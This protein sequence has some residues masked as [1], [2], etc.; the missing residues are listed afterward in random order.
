LRA[1]SEAVTPPL[2]GIE[3]DAL[4]LDARVQAA[5]ARAKAGEL[6]EST[7]RLR[8]LFAERPTDEG[9][10]LALLEGLERA[11]KTAEAAELLEAGSRAHPGSDGLLYALANAQHRSG[12]RDR[13]LITMRKLL[14]LQ[15]LHAGELSYL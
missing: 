5:L 12:Q 6:P 14:K 11:G 8:A 4:A 9:V 2:L 3:P 10:A 1:G 7:R 13:A 15:P